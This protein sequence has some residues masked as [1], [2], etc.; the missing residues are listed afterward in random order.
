[1]TFAARVVLLDGP[2]GAAKTTVAARL[3]ARFAGT[4]RLAVLEHDHFLLMAGAPEAGDAS[5]GIATASLH[6]LI[7]AAREY[8]EAGMSV[9]VVVNYGRARK[10]LLDRLLSPTPVRH[11]LLL[12]PLEVSRARVLER[13][14][15]A[16]P[17]PLPDIGWAAH[18]QFYED[19][20]SMASDG[21]FDEVIDSA[22]SIQRTDDH[23]VRH[24]G[25]GAS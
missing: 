23:L 21:D 13:L 9:L 1:M 12:P 6:A 20:C 22:G 19:L 5:E 7:A 18:R 16:A 2:P 4:G 17:P 24:L 10:E 25:L 11:V 8:V 15:S 3:Q 14:A